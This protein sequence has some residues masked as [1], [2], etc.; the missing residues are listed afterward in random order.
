SGRHGQW[1]SP[2]AWSTEGT[3]GHSFRQQLDAM[4]QLPARC[5]SIHV[6][7]ECVCWREQ[8]LGDILCFLHQPDDKLLMEQSSDFLRTLCTCFCL[9]MEKIACWVQLLVRSAWLYLPQLCHCQLTVLPS[10]HSCMF[11]LTGASKM[12]IFTE[13]IFAVQQGSSVACL[14]H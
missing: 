3:S 9:D 11:Q 6:V 14:S 10:S 12:N 13:I 1:W 7:L 8:L 5:V 2:L 4:G